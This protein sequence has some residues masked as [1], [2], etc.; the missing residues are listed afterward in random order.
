MFRLLFP[1][2]RIRKRSYAC[3]ED[4]STN[5]TTTT[6]SNSNSNFIGSCTSTRSYATTALAWISSTTAS[7]RS[8]KRSSTQRS[9]TTTSFLWL[10]LLCC[11]VVASLV[12][13]QWMM[14]L[15][16]N[17]INNNNYLSSQREQEQTF[18]DSFAED[19]LTTRS[20]NNSDDETDTSSHYDGDKNDVSSSR[21]STNTT[22]T[23]ANNNNN[24]T[25]IPLPSNTTS[26]ASS[27]IQPYLPDNTTTTTT[28][29]NSN[30]DSLQTFRQQ[31]CH[32]TNFNE[33]YNYYN[34]NNSTN[35]HSTTTTSQSNKQ[36]IILPQFMIPGSK[37]TGG[38]I[39]NHLIPYLLQHPQI[40]GRENAHSQ[41]D[42][43]FFHL[44]PHV[45]THSNYV[46]QKLYQRHYRMYSTKQQQ[47]HNKTI[48][49]DAT[50]GYLYHS[51]LLPRQ[52]LCALPWIRFIVVLNDP[53]EHIVEHYQNNNN[54]Q[55]SHK[56]NRISLHEWI[57]QD[58]K[59]LQKAGVILPTRKD[60]NDQ[61]NNN[62]EEEASFLSSSQQ[63]DV[64]WYNYLSMPEQRRGAPIGRTLYA[65]MLRHWFQALRVIGRDPAQAF[66]IVEAPKLRQQP[67][68][69]MKRISQ[70]LN[71]DDYYTRDMFVAHPSNI[72]TRTSRT[73][74][75][76]ASEWQALKEF[77]EPYNRQLAHLLRAY[78][79]S[80]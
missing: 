19:L 72:S 31:Y 6:G 52:I 25:Q 51:I 3:K 69:E 60:P 46:R 29:S 16:P 38:M 1:N 73:A 64:A 74:T 14:I 70:F 43:F 2:S 13:L 45:K 26:S 44:P 8:T 42:A 58:L 28:I 10:L 5:T 23:T 59:N 71:L 65:L 11:M 77:F 75:M 7:T 15:L 76:E 32:F 34:N 63:E 48:F 50:T 21:N 4:N 24:Y 47:Q 78:N 57:Q 54:M 12:S 66:L 33:W 67:Y 55:K 30:Q 56:N 9:T 37:F 17:N 62:E 36:Q 18:N 27:W 53:L 20:S 79:V 35:H 68:E 22:Q 39:S 40:H 61:N 49:F 80:F 41:Q